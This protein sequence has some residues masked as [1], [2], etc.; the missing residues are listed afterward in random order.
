[1]K[2]A[3]FHQIKLVTYNVKSQLEA[4]SS[5]KLFS[6]SKNQFSQVLKNKEKVTYTRNLSA[7]LGDFFGSL[8]L[9]FSQ[10]IKVLTEIVITSYSLLE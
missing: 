1:M 10:V 9:S 8:V 6:G 7:N 3:Y 2:A 5:E 4:S